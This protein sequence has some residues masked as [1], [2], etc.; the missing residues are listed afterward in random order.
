MVKLGQGVK[1]ILSYA[2]YDCGLRGKE[3]VSP[4][5]L[6]L[7]LFREDYILIDAVA[8]CYRLN[9]LKI[10][11]QICRNNPEAAVSTPPAEVA[12][13]HRALEIVLEAGLEA[14]SFGHT[15]VRPEHLFLGLME[16]K[17]SQLP[18]LFLRRAVTVQRCRELVSYLRFD[19]SVP[20]ERNSFILKGGTRMEIDYHKRR[21]T[22]FDRRQF[23]LVTLRLYRRF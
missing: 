5:H 14:E 19:S 23:E 9:S 21:D 13:G 18:D 10:L 6:L 20:A 8:A 2:A 4:D 7:A 3:I 11:E 12:F 16:F 17:R 22:M 15:R 1:R